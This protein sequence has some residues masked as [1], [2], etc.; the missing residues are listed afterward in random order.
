MSTIDVLVSAVK[1]T[2][3]QAGLV[4][5]YRQAAHTVEWTSL[6]K[7]HQ[8]MLAMAGIGVHQAKPM[9]DGDV[10]KLLEVPVHADPKSL[11]RT[12]LIF[13]AVDLRFSG[14][15]LLHLAP[16]HV[17]RT[18]SGTVTVTVPG[19]APHTVTCTCVGEPGVAVCTA[20]I[21]ARTTTLARGRTLMSHLST[22]PGHNIR[23]G[24][25]IVRQLTT[26]WAALVARDDDGLA[27][28][29]STWLSLGPVALPRS[30][31]LR[32]TPN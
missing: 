3:R 15:T 29:R 26:A 32:S 17:R 18:N 2:H 22:A 14:S 5:A 30:P 31:Y 6:R 13:S 11:A 25:V 24:R 16:E 8:R 23:R 27:D 19:D 12:A 28:V 4:A 21:L 10:E 7:G 9:R 1:E 20:C